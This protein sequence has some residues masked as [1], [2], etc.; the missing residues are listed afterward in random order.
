MHEHF[1]DP[2][3]ADP[4]RL[5]RV[6]ERT[7]VRRAPI[8]GIVEGYHTLPFLLVGPDHG[9]DEADPSDAGGAARGS[10]LLTGKISV[11]PK[12]VIPVSAVAERFADAF[13]EAEPFM[14]RALTGRVFAFATGRGKHLR[15]RNEHLNVETFAD[16][17]ALVLERVLDDLDRGEIIDHAVIW[18]PEP[19][20]Y[21]VSLEKFILSVLDREL[22]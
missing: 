13:P 2:Q 1:Q 5:R 18:C 21:P 22:R 4:E 11:S 7:E 3:G 15:V 10:V 17:D 16:S 8:T 20:L 14:D 6:F 9:D 12:L 19:R